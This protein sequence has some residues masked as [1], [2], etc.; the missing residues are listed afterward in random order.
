MLKRLRAAWIEARAALRKA[1][2]RFLGA[3][4]YLRRVR[5]ELKDVNHRLGLK[6]DDDRGNGLIR[7]KIRPGPAVRKNLD[8]WLEKRGQLVERKK[9][10]SDQVAR[11]SEIKKRWEQKEAAH[12]KAYLKHKKKEDEEQEVSSGVVVATRVWNPNRRPCA[13]GFVAICD[14]AWA[15]GWRGVLT[16]GWRS[17]EYS[18]SLCE[19]MCGNPTCP[20]RCAGRGSRHSQTPWQNGAIDVTDPWKFDSVTPELFN[21]LGAADPWHMSTS[22]R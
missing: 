21:A 3:R 13:E 10:L 14:R 5:D 20:G 18:E 11:R 9:S 6:G 17:P 8:D 7:D 15:R 19:N 1:R 22:G 16:S 2:D 12:R 4:T